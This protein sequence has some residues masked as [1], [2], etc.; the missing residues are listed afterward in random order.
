MN[1]L[2]SGIIITMLFLS[3]FSTQLKAD[4]RPAFLNSPITAEAEAK[5]LVSRLNE[6]K[7]MDKSNMTKSEKKFLRKEV[8][9]TQKKLKSLSGGVYLSVGAVIIIILLL[10][11]LL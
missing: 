9:E 6:I 3:L 8:R 7:E 4:A 1:K 2:T 11:L 5:R 10:I